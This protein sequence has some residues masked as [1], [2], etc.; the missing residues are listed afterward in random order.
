MASQLCERL[1][2]AKLMS[3]AIKRLP[4]MDAGKIIG[5]VSRYHLSAVATGEHVAIHTPV[6]DL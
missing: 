6:Y 4:V 2:I 5:I 3:H 1:S